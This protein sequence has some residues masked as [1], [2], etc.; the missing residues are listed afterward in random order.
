MIERVNVSK[1]SPMQ[2][3]AVELSMGLGGVNVDTLEFFYYGEAKYQEQVRDRLP[4]ISAATRCLRCL[5]KK[6]VLKYRRKAFRP[7]TGFDAARITRNRRRYY[8]HQKIKHVFT[9]SAHHRQLEINETLEKT[10]T[11]RERRYLN[12]L[13]HSFGYNIQYNLHDGK[14]SDKS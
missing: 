1:L 13:Q 6:K 10:L 9:Y 4:R 3:K 2:Q 7:Y 8:I 12:E 14:Q 5:V 11:P